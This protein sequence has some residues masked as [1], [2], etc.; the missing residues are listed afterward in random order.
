MFSLYVPA[1]AF[2]AQAKSV[3]NIVNTLLEFLCG[4]CETDLRQ[5]QRLQIVR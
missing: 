3:L 2:G 1:Q 5:V 4:V